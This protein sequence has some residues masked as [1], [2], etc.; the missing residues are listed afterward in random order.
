MEDKSIKD[1]LNTIELQIDN[2]K[3]ENTDLTNCE[4]IVVDVEGYRYD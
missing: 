4:T 3:Y 2:W 1:L